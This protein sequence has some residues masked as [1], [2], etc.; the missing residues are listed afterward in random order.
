MIRRIASRWMLMAVAALALLPLCRA[1]AQIVG[2][3]QGV[4]SIQ[5][6]DYHIIVHITAGNDGAFAA[7]LDSP[8]LGVTGVATSG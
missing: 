1:Q 8:E 7:T 5:G 6:T 2:D 3:W 4:A